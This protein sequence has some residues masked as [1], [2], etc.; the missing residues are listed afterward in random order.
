MVARLDAMGPNKYGHAIRAE[1]KLPSVML[2]QPVML[3]PP[4]QP[5]QPMQPMEYEHIGPDPLLAEHVAQPETGNSTGEAETGEVSTLSSDRRWWQNES[6]TQKSRTYAEQLRVALGQKPKE[7]GFCQC[8]P[9][10]SWEDRLMG[11]MGCFVIGGA[12]SIS[13]MLSFTELLLGYPTQ[14]ALKLALGNI[15]SVSSAMFLAGPRTQLQK[16]SEPASA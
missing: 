12:L 9:D 11:F 8:C 5:M 6:D 14:F 3:Q 7:D 4:M 15:L 2:Q 1:L 10:L 16:M 13:S